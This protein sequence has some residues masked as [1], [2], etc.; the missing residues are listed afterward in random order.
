MKYKLRPFTF[1]ICLIF[2]FP[3][4]AKNDSVR[5]AVKEPIVLNENGVVVEFFP[6]IING[7]KGI[8]VSS[9]DLTITFENRSNQRKL[10]NSN[11]H[12]GVSWSIKY[13]RGGK[14][15]MQLAETKGVY[16]ESFFLKPEEEK[17]IKLYYEDEEYKI[18]GVYLKMDNPIEVLSQ[19]Y[20]DKILT[21]L[22]NNGFVDV[23]H[24]Y[25]F[26]S[27]KTPFAVKVDKTKK[28]K[29]YKVEVQN[30]SEEDTYLML[31]LAAY[32][33]YARKV[34]NF[35]VSTSGSPMGMLP[36]KIK[37]GKM[38]AGEFGFI[39]E[40]AFVKIIAIETYKSL[41]SSKKWESKVFLWGNDTPYNCTC[42]ANLSEFLE[43]KKIVIPPCNNI[44]ENNNVSIQMIDMVEESIF[45]PYFKNNPV[46]LY[47]FDFSGDELIPELR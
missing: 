41:G 6:K 33:P 32:D 3:V 29:A 31:I 35:H 14:P 21:I 15:L 8:T 17:V 19:N 25:E 30:L 47:L 11:L 42:V 7:I 16:N 9:C 12:F 45:T 39:L 18:D 36:K 1:L 38:Q 10:V 24:G 34:V 44:G 27:D 5:I 43:I 22:K 23:A 2:T 37:S 20:D 13:K 26:N 40:K 4:F 28:G 46:P